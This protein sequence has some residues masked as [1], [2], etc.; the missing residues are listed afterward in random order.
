M[1]SGGAWRHLTARLDALATAG[2]TLD[3]WLR[4]D[5][6]IE[7]TPAL[8][9]LLDFGAR[10]Q[11][12]LLLAVVPAGAGQPL[13]GL[14]R[15][16]ETVRV[17]QHGFD[18]ANHAPAGT[19][20]RELGPDRPVETILAALRE[21]A[22][23]LRTLFD[24]APLPML[25]PPWNRIDPALL[26]A[27]PGLGF[28]ALSAFGAEPVMPDGLVALNTH[29]DIIDWRGS[30]GGYPADRLVAML[31][32][33][34]DRRAHTGWPLAPLGILTHHLVHD[35]AAWRFLDQLAACLAGHSAARWVD[36]C[37]GMSAASCRSAPSPAPG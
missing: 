6:A 35:A 19:K 5:D 2:R 17:A 24:P 33:E 20:S 7:P 9:R 29:V 14:L 26:P 18:H 10:H 3:L 37:A 28:R 34:I 30:R 1:T 21:G 31:C 16:L 36:A 12:P 15:G 23:K 22:G 32:A 8:D 11:I 27:L 25:V 4:D 13:A